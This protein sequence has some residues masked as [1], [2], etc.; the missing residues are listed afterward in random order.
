[1]TLAH[2]MTTAFT[3]VAVAG[4]TSTVRLDEVAAVDPMGVAVTRA[5]NR[6]GGPTF[7][8]PVAPEV[9]RTFAVEPL[10]QM[11]VWL[12]RVGRS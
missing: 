7:L 12:R 6:A 4:T 9:R 11:A 5:L 1:M 2:R 3:S 10:V 8:R